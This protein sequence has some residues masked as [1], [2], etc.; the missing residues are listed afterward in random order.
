M[1]DKRIIKKYPNRRLYDT[2]VSKYIT[3]EDLKQLVLE[4]KE[5]T[6]VDVKTEEDLTRSV[7]LQIIAEQEHGGEPIFSTDALTQIIRFYGD[8]IQGVASQFLTQSLDLFTR[9]HKKVQEQL[10]STVSNDPMTAM[11]EL[12]QKNLELWQD[13]QKSFYEAAGLSSG[14]TSTDKSRKK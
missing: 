10:K 5:F 11:T 1:S 4:G 9:Q 12:T 14:K 13:M 8:S 6:V 2:E 3:M 7:L